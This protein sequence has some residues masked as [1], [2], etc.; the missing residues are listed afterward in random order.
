MKHAVKWMLC[1]KPWFA[2]L[3][4]TVCTSHACCCMQTV[5][6]A[7]ASLPWTCLDTEM[8][9]KINFGE[10]SPVAVGWAGSL[11]RTEWI[12][13]PACS[14]SSHGYSALKQQQLSR[15]LGGHRLIPPP[16]T[17]GLAW[18]VRDLDWDPQAYIVLLSF[19]PSPVGTS[20]YVIFNV[21]SCISSLLFPPR[22]LKCAQHHIPFLCSP[23]PERWVRWED[24]DSSNVPF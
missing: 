15:V 20:M 9:G 4:V 22:S 16:S 7:A 21:L 14:C 2:C 8:G 24:T 13:P 18:E 12:R 3:Q 19:G 17:W 10:S 11:E 23:N 6:W 1:G 5:V